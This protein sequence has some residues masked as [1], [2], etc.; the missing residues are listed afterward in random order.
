MFVCLFVWIC[1][2]IEREIGGT[3]LGYSRGNEQHKGV[4]QREKL[5][6][7]NVAA[8]IHLLNGIFNIFSSSLLRI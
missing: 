6:I 5:L 8:I 2:E 3:L 7:L 1:K 4:Q